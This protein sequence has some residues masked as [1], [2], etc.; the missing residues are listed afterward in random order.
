MLSKLKRVWVVGASSGIGLALAKALDDRE[1]TL[2][3]SARR[4]QPLKLL[5]TTARSSLHVLPMDMTD[6]F[7]VGSAA[8][9]I[10]EQA[11]SLDMLIVNAGTCEYIDGT[12]LDMELT[13]RVME[14]NF[15]GAISV[16]NRALPLLKKSVEEGNRPK[17]VVMSSSVTYQALPRAHAYGASKAALRYFADCLKIDLQAQ[18][19]DVHIVS[20]GF[21]RTPLTDVNDFPMPFRL[22]ADD[23]AKRIIKGLQRNTFDIH[24]PLRFTWILKT[25][26]MLPAKIRF[27]LLAK[28]ARENTSDATAHHS[29]ESL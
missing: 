24:F 18:G 12:D 15:F 22:D 10:E 16:I 5:Q 29:G 6:E 8:Q 25:L 4:E 11:S 3:V 9:N 28:L 23:A 19:I 20:P 14:T 17:L 7:E 26:A 2:F 1:R 27:A 13:R 21:V